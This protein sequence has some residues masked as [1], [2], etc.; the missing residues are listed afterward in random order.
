MSRNFL[1]QLFVYDSKSCF[2]VLLLRHKCH[3]YEFHIESLLVSF[4]QIK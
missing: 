1:I 2:N 3:C 4:Q